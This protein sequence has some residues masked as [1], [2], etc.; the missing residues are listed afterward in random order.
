MLEETREAL[1]EKAHQSGM[2]DIATGTLHNVGNILNSVKTSAQMIQEMAVGGHLLS[3]FI[4]AN[5]L[6]RKNIDTRPELTPDE[7][8]RTHCQAGRQSQQ[9]APESR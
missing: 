2:A 6:L 4:K 3:G 7:K 9:I 5:D 1:I 8:I